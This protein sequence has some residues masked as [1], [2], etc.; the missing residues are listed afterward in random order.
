MKKIFIFLFTFLLLSC[1]NNK[2]VKWYLPHE[3]MQKE[4]NYLGKHRTAHIQLKDDQTFY[5]E[6]TNIISDSLTCINKQTSNYMRL[7]VS[8][9]Y[10]ITFKDHFVGFAY[11]FVFGVGAGTAFG[12]LIVDPDAEMS[13]LGI[14]AGM[15]SGAVIGGITG[16]IFGSNLNYIILTE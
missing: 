4:L 3:K 15:V 5:A 8:E 13:G 6:K 11:G 1:A 9:I 7:S 10:K 16:L 14:L 12:L 2:L